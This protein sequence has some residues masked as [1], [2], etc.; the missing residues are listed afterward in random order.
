MVAA[1]AS[2]T[3]PAAFLPPSQSTVQLALPE[4]SAPVVTA[5]ATPV[6]EPIGVAAPTDPNAIPALIASVRQGPDSM[7]WFVFGGTAAFL[8]VIL[9]A[10]WLVTGR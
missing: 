2:V 10:I 4:I 5:V 8:C 6:P 1:S 9:M 3:S 7:Q